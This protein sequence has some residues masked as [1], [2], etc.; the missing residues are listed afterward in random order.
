VSP[1]NEDAKGTAGVLVLVV[2]PSG[3]GKDTVLRLAR[4]EFAAD[5]RFRFPRRAITRA[6]DPS[7]DHE[8]LSPDA[9]AAGE[10]RGAFALSWRA[11]GLCYGVPAE[12]AG[13]LASGDIV[14]VNVSRSIVVKARAR[15]PGAKVALVA[16]QPETLAARLAAR[17]RD[18][19]A[20]RRLSREAVPTEELR[21]DLIVHN[22]GRAEQAA[23]E[24]IR[25]LRGLAALIDG[26][27]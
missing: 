24:F 26:G 27:A 6:S 15:F 2:G 10:A 17:G 16:A 20:S 21:P 5:R 23:G 9:F 14:A 1:D 19:D 4:Q 12:I 13:A 7:E 25:F 22:D 8:S 18:P 11:H 3:A